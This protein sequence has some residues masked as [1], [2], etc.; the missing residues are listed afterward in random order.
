MGQ[1][2]LPPQEAAKSTFARNLGRVSV[3]LAISLMASI[4][5]AFWYGRYFLNERLSPLLEVELNKAIKRPLQLGKVERIGMSSIRFGKSLVPPT[6]K[7]SN[8]LAVEAIEVKVDPWT[9]L[10]HRQIGLDAVVEQPQVFLKQDVTGF[11]QLPKITPPERPTQEGLIDLRKITFNDA[12]ITIQSISKGE[13]VSRSQV[14][15]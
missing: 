7:E 5:G 3:G 4:L 13:L 10:T 15:I 2:Q 14:Q 12:Q 1:A 11:L 6:D 8:F 9:Y